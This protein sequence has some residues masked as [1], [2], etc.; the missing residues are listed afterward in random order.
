MS[1]LYIGTIGDKHETFEVHAITNGFPFR[2]YKK[3]EIS[4]PGLFRELVKS[5]YKVLKRGRPIYCTAVN[6]DII[7][8]TETNPHDERPGTVHIA[9]LNKERNIV[10]GSSLAIDLLEKDK[11]EIIGLPLENRWERNNYPEGDNLDKFRKKYLRLNYNLQRDILPGE[12]VELYRHFKLDNTRSGNVAPRLA[13]YYGAY[14]LLKRGA[15]KNGIVPAW[16]W[17]FDSIP[18]YFNLYRYAGAAVL[19]D[20]SIN[21]ASH[22]ISPGKRDLTKKAKEKSILYEDSVISRN[23]LVPIPKKHKD[24]LSF[25]TREVPF[26]D[27]VIDIIKIE[28]SAYKYTLTMRDLKHKG[29]NYKDLCRI[30]GCLCTIGSQ[31]FEDFHRYNVPANILN[32]IQRKFTRTSIIKH[33]DVGSLNMN[34]RQKKKILFKIH[35]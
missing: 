32:L 33:S 24:G 12:L 19:R 14:N 11:G 6:P 29:I 23:I 3:D 21:E 16:I 28:K 13:V 15:N 30:R 18:A 1:S 7:N 34:R 26:L 2:G 35:T 20:S 4:D 22:L 8:E 9:V 25:A 27:G 5:R 17:V 31:T 10:S